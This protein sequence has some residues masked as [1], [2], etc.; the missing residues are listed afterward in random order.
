M[1]NINWEFVVFSKF[2]FQESNLISID[3]KLDLK[4]DTSCVYVLKKRNISFRSIFPN[5]IWMYFI[6]IRNDR[7]E[8]FII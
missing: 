7:R 1:R 3:R 2:W 6:T 5:T 8:P 4:S